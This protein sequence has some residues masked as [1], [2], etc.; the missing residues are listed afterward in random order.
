[1]GAQTPE[2]VKRVRRL[3]LVLGIAA[4]VAGAACRR[5]VPDSEKPAPAVSLVQPGAPGQPTRQLPPGTPATTPPKH[6]AADV[7]FMQGMIHHHAQ[8][9]EMVELLKTRTKRE[10]MKRLG[11]RIE[12]SQTDE[13]KMMK[14]WLADR[15]M[16]V[17]MDHGH[18]M[19]M[20]GAAMGPMSG[21]LTPAQMAAL[22]KAAGPSFDRLFL[23]GMIQHH[24]GALAMVDELRNSP[25]AAQESV[26]FDF[27]THVD[28]DQRMEIARM[29]QMLKDT[30]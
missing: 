16:E 24:E 15:S 17:P 19:M 30:P 22:E 14:T 23:T 29:R 27:V 9:V 12:V 7:T 18:A 3:V 8:A 28:A 6:T 11:Q 13:I 26:I 21:M 10:D 5:A 20:A 4:A 25:G 1:V 2:S